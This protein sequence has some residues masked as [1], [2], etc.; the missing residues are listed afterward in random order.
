MSYKFLLPV[1]FTCEICTCKTM[2]SFEVEINHK[3]TLKSDGHESQYPDYPLGWK[4]DTCVRCVA[5]Q[6]TQ[7]FHR[8]M[9]DARAVRE[10]EEAKKA[11]A[12]ERQDTLVR[13]A[14]SAVVKTAQLTQCKGCGAIVQPDHHVCP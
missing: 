14:I 4:G 10:A 1:Q 8:E 7:S 6:A 13:Q 3:G 5:D 2:G 12:R 11:V 9:D